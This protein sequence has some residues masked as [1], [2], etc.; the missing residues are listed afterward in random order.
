MEVTGS[1][2]WF[3]LSFSSSWAAHPEHS[4]MVVAKMALREFGDV[5]TSHLSIQCFENDAKE[6]TS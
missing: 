1:K 5:L 3:R 4:P 6:I 2:D